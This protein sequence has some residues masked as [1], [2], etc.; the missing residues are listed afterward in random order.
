MYML[1]VFL[2]CNLF[3]ATFLL[4]LL[5][6]LQGVCVHIKK[7]AFLFSFG[8]CY[9]FMFNTNHIGTQTQKS[10]TKRYS[11]LSKLGVMLSPH[12]HAYITV[13]AFIAC[14]RN[15]YQRKYS[16]I[17]SIRPMRAKVKENHT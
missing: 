8:R 10:K 14:M 3:M 7:E 1:F 13:V 9:I 15:G 2:F 5:F 6:I 12:A 16:N 4:V 11:M 17:S